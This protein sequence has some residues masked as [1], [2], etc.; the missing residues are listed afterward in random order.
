MAIGVYR[1]LLLA[2]L[3]TACAQEGGGGC[4]CLEPLPDGAYPPD[5]LASGA[6]QLRLTDS[7]I[8]FIETN[9]PAII[10]EFVQLSCGPNEPVTCPAGTTCGGGRC[11]ENGSPAP[12]IGIKI[13]PSSGSG[14]NIC[15]GASRSGCNAYV[16]VNTVEVNPVEP[17]NLDVVLRADLTS[18]GINLHRPGTWWPPLPTIRCTV[19]A[20]AINKRIGVPVTVRTDNPLRRTEFEVGDIGFSIENDDIELCGA[21][22]WPIIKDIIM[23][24]M[25]G[26]IEGMLDEQIGEALAE[27]LYV[28]SAN[29]CPAP[30][31]AAGDFCEFDNGRRVPVSMGV[32]GRLDLGILL[33]EAGLGGSGAPIDLGLIMG[34][35]AQVAQSGLDLGMLGGAD[36]ELSG[37]ALDIS[38]LPADVIPLQWGNQV[39]GSDTDFHLGLGISESFL[40]ALGSAM[41][42]GGALCLGLDSESTELINSNT[43]G[44]IMPS[45]SDLLAGHAETPAPMRLRL[46][47]R[48]PIDM[49]VGLGRYEDQEGERVMVEPLIHLAAE[50]FTIQFELGLAGRYTRVATISTNL[51]VGLGLDLDADNNL[52][53]TMADPA[54][55][56]TDIEVTN[57]DILK[58]TN[59]E[60]AEVI[61]ALLELALPQLTG[62]LDQSI[63]LPALSGF[64]LEVEAIRGERV[65]PEP[66]PDNLGRYDFLAFYSRLSFQPG[67][68]APDHLR[69]RTSAEVIEVESGRTE[70]YDVTHPGALFRPSVRVALNLHGAGERGSYE[71]TWRVG[72]GIWRHFQSVSDGDQV[73]L[74]S[75]IFS[76]QGRHA[77][78]LRARVK[79]NYRTLDSEGARFEV[80]IDTVAPEF[81]VVEWTPG[82]DLAVAA[83]DAVWGQEAVDVRLFAGSELLAEGRGSLTLSGL[84]RLADLRL[85][86]VDGSGNQRVVNLTGA[87]RRQLVVGTG[88]LDLDASDLATAEGCSCAGGGVAGLLW[89]TPLLLAIRRRRR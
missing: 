30:S 58:E 62:A 84:D 5:E 64:E 59:E 51:A 77:V 61:P 13:P 65:Q 24:A 43:L 15:H 68:Q 22:D 73:V 37:C 67:N 57:T 48:Q 60:I 42:R 2:A 47:P 88:P 50:D 71:Y 45:L 83:T 31:H 40:D 1:S 72:D 56:M 26:Q 74:R 11:L 4:G 41:Y 49:S 12:I 55:W 81:D 29:G 82:A 78:T 10:S 32:E 53:I 80:V 39:P 33:G 3:L 89:L 87:D 6:G 19:Y 69:V 27:T 8:A 21:L 46:T 18:T 79:G 7:G 14:V 20:N 9:L 76:L 38:R 28:A 66:G 16:R 63:A 25:R 86:A 23:A 52:M 75:P 35:S 54:D 44:L 34:G 36:A 17:T 70:A 85:E